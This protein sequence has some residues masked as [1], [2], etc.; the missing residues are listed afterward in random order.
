MTFWI[1]A[2]LLVF[3]VLAL[4]LLALLREGSGA[5]K[6]GTDITVYRDQL[7]EVDR[8]LARGVLTAEEADQIRIE[9]SRRLL[10]A[11][12]K[13]TAQTE[14]GVAPRGA[15]W[16]MSAV[17][18]LAL[19]GGTGA[20]YSTIGAPGYPDLPL[21]GRIA[22]ANDA[23]LDR[24]S[25]DA[26]EAR[27]AELDIPAPEVDQSFLDLMDDLRS[28]L[29]ERPDDLQG[30]M[31][32]AR[33]EANVGNFAAAQRAQRRVIELKGDTATAEDYAV[34]AELMVVAARGYVSKDAEDLLT[35]TL[36]RDPTNGTARYLSGLM[37]IQTGRPDIAFNLWS[38]LL[39]TSAPDA[40]W[41]PAIQSQ[42]VELAARAG[43]R[44]DPL[45]GPSAADVEAAS[46]MSDEDRAAMIEGMV[47]GLSDRLAT[48]GGPPADWAQLIRALGVLG[49]TEQAAAIWTEA[50]EVFPDPSMRAPIDEAAEAAGLTE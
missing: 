42:I 38:S 21:D 5:T 14:A 40:P 12:R 26:A 50:Q 28:A 46:E 10:E 16:A 27:V 41:V 1:A 49:R 31:L 3:A 17:T 34:R 13:A 22:D 29:K 39:E 43:V 15:S 2:L 18:G 45:S 25:Q 11:D 4:L 8:D 44:Y 19:I 33:N 30:H 20:L 37:M 32:L 24:D 35:E 48:E 7:D 6:G 47:S 36:R 9:V 23:R